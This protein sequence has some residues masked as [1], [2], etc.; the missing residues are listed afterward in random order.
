MICEIYHSREFFEKLFEKEK[1]PI[2]KLAVFF[3]DKLFDFIGGWD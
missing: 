2:N 3:N 1:L